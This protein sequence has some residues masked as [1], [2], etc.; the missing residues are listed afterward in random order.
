MEAADYRRTKATKAIVDRL[1]HDND[2][3]VRLAAVTALNRMGTYVHDIVL[4]SLEECIKAQ[5]KCRY[6]DFRF[7]DDAVA[8]V[9]QHC[10]TPRAAHA[11]IQFV[12][13]GKGA[14][15][16]LHAIRELKEIVSPE[17]RAAVFANI[18]DPETHYVSSASLNAIDAVRH[19]AA[20]ILVALN[21]IRVA[22]TL[23]IW[24][25]SNWD[26]ERR[27]AARLLGDL[28][29]DHLERVSRLLSHIHDERMVGE[30]L[31][32]LETIMEHEPHT[33]SDG[34]IKEMRSLKKRLDA[35]VEHPTA[36]LE[37]KNFFDEETKVDTSRLKQLAEEEARKRKQK[38]NTLPTTPTP[39]AESR[40]E[41]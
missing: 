12:L 34:D 26:P 21:D 20:S 4:A 24:L 17:D 31:H 13:L 6:Y 14:E 10:R 19:G 40:P 39:P 35:V 9:L 32:S 3:D 5:I 38:S 28:R 33:A 41:G 8:S 37:R 7:P 25:N 2:Q 15:K 30:V 36:S 22:D 29:C 23:F 27:V 1:L 18:R 16:T 11:L